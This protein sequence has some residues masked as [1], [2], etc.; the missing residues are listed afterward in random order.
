MIRIWFSAVWLFAF[1]TIAS[2]DLGS[3][4]DRLFSD[5]DKPDVPG[6]SVLVMRTGTVTLRKS[7]GLADVGKKESVREETN[8]RMAS[9]TKQF[10]AMAAVILVDRGQ[11]RLDEKLT[12]IFPDFPAYGKNIQVRHLLNHTGGMRDYEDLIPASQT[13]QVND[14][15]VLALLKKESSGYFTPGSQYRYSNGG[16]CVLAQI[17]EKKS[18]LK[19]GEFVTKNI[20]EPLSMTASRVYDRDDVPQIPYR[21]Y[22]YT[23]SG[24][25]FQKTDQ[26]VT[27][28]TQGDGGVY[29]SSMDYE[30]WARGLDT[31]AS[32]SLVDQIFTAG[33]LNDGSSTTYGFGWV[34]DTY[35]GTKR[36]SHTGSTIGFRSAVQRFPEY[37]ATIAVF[38]NRAGAAPWDLAQRAAD[39]FL[40]GDK[41]P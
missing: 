22:G 28:A 18:G 16:Y 8:F 24:S 4:L 14:A 31:L 33:K 15:D 5:Y 23:R 11:L 26:S 1:S 41:L 17:V 7:Y 3:D 13:K 39:L 20:F 9:L 12:E 2:A 32:A 34:L 40:F 27:S 36:R 25:G 19:F 37:D 21:A 6:A 35:R 38:V 10:T 30:R 29:T